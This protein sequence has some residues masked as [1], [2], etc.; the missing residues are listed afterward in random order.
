MGGSNPLNPIPRSAPEQNTLNAR[1][2]LNVPAV[3]S[4]SMKAN[5]VMAGT[6]CKS[7]YFS[8]TQFS[9]I[10]NFG[11]LARK[12]FSLILNSLHYTLWPFK[13]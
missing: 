9:L 13:F 10:S 2:P 1:W 8:G 7:T 12:K 11:H 3:T 5:L 4:F 6:Y